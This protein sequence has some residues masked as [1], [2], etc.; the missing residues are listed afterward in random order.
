MN[1]KMLTAILTIVMVA[2][3][4]SG[5]TVAFFS[6]TE[7]SRGNT[8][9]TGTPVDLKIKDNNEPWGDGVTAT[10][11]M[12]NMKPGDE[13]S[14]LIEQVDLKNVGTVP[15]AT[16]DIIVINNIMDPPGPESDTEEG[17]TD[18]DEM[19]QITWMEYEGDSGVVN[20]LPL[21]GD[22]NGNGWKDLDDLEKDPI[23]GLE[24]P[25]GIARFQLGLRFRFE[26]DND[27]Q[28]DTLVSDFVFTFNQ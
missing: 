24:A 2:V 13:L 25:T 5:A 12:S 4:A 18:M 11:T 9:T 22:D 6:D 23:I 1:R 27:Y 14:G 21:L 8:I 20:L 15:A 3:L 17:T 26:A 16:L 7:T 28:G 10:W 19:M